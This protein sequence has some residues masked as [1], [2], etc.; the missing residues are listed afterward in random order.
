VAVWRLVAFPPVSAFLSLL[1]GRHIHPTP[2]PKPARQN[3]AAFSKN[4]FENIF[5]IF[6][7]GF[8]V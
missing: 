1:V 7:V 5:F 4:F 2:P 3:R 8:F 6:S